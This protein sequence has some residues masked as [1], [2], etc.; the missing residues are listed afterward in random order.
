MGPYEAA[1]STPDKLPD[2]SDSLS[3]RATQQLA[4]WKDS[5]EADR[6]CF[7]EVME[8]AKKWGNK[9]THEEFAEKALHNLK[10]DTAI[11][12]KEDDALL[13]GTCNHSPIPPPLKK[14][15]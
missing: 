5:H 3:K 2:G 1:P 8:V 12:G 6:K 15:L 10:V 7:L 9:K 14:K 13:H 11:E 4:A